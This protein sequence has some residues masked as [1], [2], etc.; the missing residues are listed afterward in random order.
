MES[1]Q[2]AS[3]QS[4]ASVSGKP[5]RPHSRLWRRAW[6]LLIVLSLLGAGVYLIPMII[7]VS[8]GY[9]RTLDAPEA[10]IRLEIVNAS[11]ERALGAAATRK[12][13]GYVDRR[14]EIA[15]VAD[16]TFAVRPVTESFIISREEDVS[17]ARLLAITLGL[18]PSAVVYRPL[19]NNTRCVSA[20]LILGQDA[21]RIAALAP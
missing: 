17:S 13:S 6:D 3:D 2:S 11:G 5:T 8:D 1:E 15:V 20:T 12:L 18:D 4:S 7:R 9:T 16:E 14:V 19:D 10:I 21:S